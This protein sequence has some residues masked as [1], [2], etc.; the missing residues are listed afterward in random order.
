MKMDNS[1]NLKDI[2]QEYL[3]LKGYSLP[4]LQQATGIP[5]RYL[6][7]MIKGE[8]HKMPAAPY[9]RGYL[10]KIAEVLNMDG[11]ELWRQYQKEMEIKSSGPSDRLPEN[12]F[13]IKSI[14][15]SWII[16]IVIL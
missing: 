10:L 14:K 7:A 2:L 1:K 12:R 6:E 5:E 16:G 9:F 13:A 8:F 15:K 4:R 11:Q 3:E